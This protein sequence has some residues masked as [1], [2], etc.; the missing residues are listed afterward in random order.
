MRFG[1]LNMSTWK[2]IPDTIYEFSDNG[3][4]RNS[5]TLKILNGTKYNY[6]FGSILKDKHKK[7]RRSITFSKQ[8]ASL[9]IPNPEHYEYVKHIDCNVYNNHVSNLQWVKHPSNFYKDQYC[10]TSED[11]S[12]FLGNSF[13]NVDATEWKIFPEN[14]NYEVSTDGN[15]RNADTKQHLTV[16]IKSNSRPY[17]GLTNPT[18]T[19]MLYRV[20]A[21]TFIPNPDN[22]P[23]IDH[24]DRDPLNNKV[25]NLRW[26][27]TKEQCQ[28]KSP[29]KKE[30]TTHKIW[31]INPITKDK[32]LFDNTKSAVQWVLDQQL[33]TSSAGAFS[34]IGKVLNKNPNCNTAYGYI[35]E[36]DKSEINVQE[37]WKDISTK[38]Q[39]AKCYLF[40][41]MGNIKDPRGRI[42]EGTIGKDNRKYINIGTKSSN[43][44]RNTHAVSRLVALL[45]VPN[46]DIKNNIVDHKNGITLDNR[47]ENL[48]WVTSKENNQRAVDTMLRTKNCQRIEV[49]SNET[50]TIYN[51]LKLASI[52]INIGVNTIR[53]YSKNNTIYTKNRINYTFRYL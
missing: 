45:F 24:I 15:V 49:T 47:A 2:C 4:L 36:Y 16:S 8:I 11:K 20:I 1:T 18:K 52:S 50:T 48:Q 37:E 35:W 44:K 28:N 7:R 25:S 34:T 38:I 17:I 46:D 29:R 40:S 6:G 22:K 13:V 32:F 5:M 21:L 10:N 30:K 51:T 9:F 31:R 26:A 39:D 3:E 27:T 19:W 33:S 14:T 12:V 41:N 42:I 43:G 53:K 23:T